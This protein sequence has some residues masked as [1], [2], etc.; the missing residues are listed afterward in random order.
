MKK[1]KVFYHGRAFF[2]PGNGTALAEANFYG[3]PIATHLVLEK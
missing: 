1:V 2:V 3:D